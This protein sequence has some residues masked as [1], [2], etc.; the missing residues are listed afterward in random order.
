MLLVLIF[1]FIF[2]TEEICY[3]AKL[4]FLFE[5]SSCSSGTCTG[6]GTLNLNF[7]DVWGPFGTHPESSIREGLV[8]HSGS[9]IQ[10]DNPRYILY[11]VWVDI[12]GD[13]AKF[14]MFNIVE[15][16]N[17]QFFNKIELSDGVTTRTNYDLDDSPGIHHFVTIIDTLTNNVKVYQNALFKFSTDDLIFNYTDTVIN[18]LN[19]VNTDKFYKVAMY[20]GDF[21]G[22]FI[23]QELFNSGS[24]YK[25]HFLSL[26]EPDV[27]LNGTVNPNVTW[28]CSSEFNQISQQIENLF[29]YFNETCG[30][31]DLVEY[32]EQLS[33]DI[34]M[35]FST[36]INMLSDYNMTFSQI[37]NIL[38][39]FSNQ[40]NVSVEILL[41]ILDT[42]QSY[43]YTSILLDNQQYLTQILDILLIQDMNMTLCLELLTN[44]ITKLDNDTDIIIDLL[45]QLLNRPEF[46]NTQIL[47]ILS[48]LEQSSEDTYL[49]VTHILQHLLSQ[50]MYNSTVLIILF[51]KLADLSTEQ[52]EI[53]FQVLENQ[54]Y[55]INM[56]T[57][58]VNMGDI[59]LTMGD[60]LI[61][62]GD[63]FYDL[64]AHLISI[65][66]NSQI[67][68]NTIFEVLIE[69]NEIMIKLENIFLQK[70]MTYEEFV[71]ILEILGDLPI[72]ELLQHMNQSHI[73]RERLLAE[74]LLLKTK[75][76]SFETFLLVFCG[77]TTVS[78]CFQYLNNGNFI[79]NV[80]QITIIPLLIIIMFIILTWIIIW[81]IRK[82]NYQLE[83][84]YMY[85]KLHT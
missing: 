33:V 47:L 6:L 44:L 65:T 29:V 75:C 35:N 55:T 59:L 23:A 85:K 27:C 79:L 38:T 32:L 68:L 3:D 78:S 7:T 42:L 14:N 45:V 37:F 19:Y 36:V 11:D 26:C 1:I 60:S 76:G 63:D 9:I 51:D 64:F 74:I 58:I 73:D 41:E 67:F 2:S 30:L 8:V 5:G 40:Q 82:W 61:Q 66:N 84:T 43:N 21:S 48:K 31:E 20:Y 54:N 12:E 71:Y 56:L 17:G 22:D 62:M 10:T 50:E 80:L 4:S 46:N 57:M 16:L 28:S 52:L 18:L 53:L 13:K 69:N 49:V 77:N 15:L 24:G 39:F 34:N 83:P 25:Y 70:N 81:L 72:F